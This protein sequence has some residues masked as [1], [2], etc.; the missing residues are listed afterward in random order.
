M[1]KLVTAN[2][3]NNAEPCILRYETSDNKM[4]KIKAD[5][6]DADIISHTYNKGEGQVIFNKSIS[7]IEDYAFI[8]CIS[9]TSATIPDS[10]TRIGVGVFRGC[11][12][13]RA[14]YGNFASKDNRCLI[15]DSVLNSFAPAGIT[16]YTIPNSVTSI[17]EGAF[18]GCHSLTSITIPNSVTEIGKETFISCSFVSIMIPDNVT[19]IRKQAFDS[20]SDLTSVTIPDSVTEIGERAFCS[21]ESLTSITIGNSV[22]EIGYATFYNCR[23]LK[24]I[25]CKASTPPVLEKDAFYKIPVDATIIIP[26]GCEDAYMNSD[27]KS[28]FEE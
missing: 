2:L 25:I 17:G 10:V 1:P 19:S 28:L 21:C 11:S 13:L 8:D 9:L 6:F 26:E 16:E 5:R 23:S 20:C 15:I 3:S 18:A 27:W 24:T 4:L 12:S 22:T 14:F 7:N